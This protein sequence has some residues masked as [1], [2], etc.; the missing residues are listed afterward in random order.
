VETLTLMIPAITVP[1]DSRQADMQTV[2][3]FS[4]R[5]PQVKSSS[6]SQFYMPLCFAGTARQIDF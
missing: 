1:A 6:Q 4:M 5:M 2:A 3:M